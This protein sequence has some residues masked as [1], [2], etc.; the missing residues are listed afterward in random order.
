M[1]FIPAQ[2]QPSPMTMAIVVCTI[3]AL[4]WMDRGAV[5][6]G[7]VA[8]PARSGFRVQGLELIVRQASSSLRP[9]MA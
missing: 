6:R 7:F 8:D 2:L 9:A 5:L 3:S 4:W 1:E